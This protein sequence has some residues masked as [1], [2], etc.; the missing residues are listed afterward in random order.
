MS[1][2]TVKAL[3]R[4]L[5]FCDLRLKSGTGLKAEKFITKI[6]SGH[7]QL[8]SSHFPVISFGR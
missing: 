4:N 7:L 3:N 6:V 5:K 8:F 1:C 2:R